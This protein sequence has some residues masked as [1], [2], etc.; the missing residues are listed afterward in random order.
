MR[1]SL[2]FFSFLLQCDFYSSYFP[3]FYLHFYFYLYLYSN[4]YFCLNFHLGIAGNPISEFIELKKLVPLKY[5]ENLILS[6]VHF[7]QC[8][9]TLLDGYREFVICFLLQVRYLDGVAINK[10][11]QMSANMAYNNKVSVDT[12]FVC[13]KIVYTHMHAHTHMHTHTQTT[14]R[15]HSKP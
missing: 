7:G 2:S 4:Y 8:P 15:T 12:D 14:S 11:G 6:D 13:M 1:R 9:L 3:H 5:L 10:A